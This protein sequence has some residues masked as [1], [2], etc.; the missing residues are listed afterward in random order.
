MS[1]TN[2]KSKT[3][4]K[5][6]SFRVEPYIDNYIHST[7]EQKGYTVSQYIQECVLNGQVADLSMPRR[8]FPCVAAINTLL[9]HSDDEELVMSIRKEL[10]VIC[11]ALK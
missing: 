8:I 11:R 3:K 6:I 5:T 4:T 1:Y 7:A 9:E 2:N 10:D